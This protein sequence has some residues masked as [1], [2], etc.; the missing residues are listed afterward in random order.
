MFFIDLDREEQWINRWV[1]QGWR[2]KS[3]RG[4]RYEFVPKETFRA[5]PERGGA[6]G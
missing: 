1:K 6:S 5:P 4:I 3:I 2:L